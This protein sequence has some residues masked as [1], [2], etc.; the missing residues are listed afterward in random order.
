MDEFAKPLFSSNG[1]FIIAIQDSSVSLWPTR[2]LILNPYSTLD[3]SV[4]RDDFL[5]AFSLDETL[6]AIIQ[7][8][9]K[10]VT[11]L[12][13]ESGDP[14]LVIDAG[15][16]ISCLRVTGSTLAVASGREVVAWDIHAR[17]STLRT[18]V[19][20]DDSVHTATLTP[21]SI[22]LS[23][24]TY[25]SLSPDLSYVAVMNGGGELPPDNLQ[26]YDTWTGE[27]LTSTTTNPVQFP[28][29]TP[30]GHEIWC[31]GFFKSVAGWSITEEKEHRSTE[32]HQQNRLQL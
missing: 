21:F 31:A 15:M 4:S 19:Y 30:G 28:H 32:L 8:E 11:V 9:E 16:R 17:D 10:T 12:N 3:Q 18:K 5:P 27:H 20:I 24:I 7:P 25:T 26:I 1:E 23:T 22:Q 6:A 14:R 13:L 2:S 29:F